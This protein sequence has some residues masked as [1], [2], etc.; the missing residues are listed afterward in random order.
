MKRPILI[1]VVG[2]IIGIIIG[3]YF[4]ISIA[5]FYVVLFLLYFTIKIIYKNIK[6][7]RF[8]FYSISR[9]LRY[10]KL[11]INKKI[12]ILLIVFSCISNLIINT[13]IN[14]YNQIY[15]T[16]KNVEIIAKIEDLQEEKQYQNKYRINTLKLNGEEININFFLITSSKKYYEYGD[17]VFIKGEYIA[18]SI[19]RNYGGFDYSKY[20]KT[21]NIYGTIKLTNI[22]LIEKQKGF[23][24]NKMIYNLRDF[25]KDN[26]QKY[27]PKDLYSIYLGLI[28][29]DTTYIEDETMDNF[30]DSNMAHIL[31]VSGM[32]ISYIVI[33]ISVFLNKIFGKRRTK[34]IS[35]FIIL[36]Y[37]FITGFS[38]SIIRASIM[39]IM[40]LLSGLFNRKDDIWNSIA[41]S[42]FIILIYNPFL[43]TSISLQY[44]YLGIIGIIVF[45]NSI[46]QF[47]KRKSEKH[48]RLKQIVAF[49]LSIQIFIFPLS[50]YYFNKFGIYFIFTNIVLSVII[51]PLIVYSF[52]FL[53]LL[54]IRFPLINIAAIPLKAGITIIL[55][56]SNISKLPFSK[57]NV[58]TPKIHEIIIF[59]IVMILINLIYKSQSKKKLTNS[60][61]RLKL[62]YQLFKY[63]LKSKFNNKR[64]RRKLLIICTIIVFTIYSI[65]TIRPRELQIHFVDVGQGDCC[66]IET[67][68]NKTI[69]I[70][71][72]GAEFGDFDVGKN[73]VLPYLLDI[74]YTKID[75]VIISHFDTDHI[76][77]VLTIIKELNVGQVVVSKQAEISSN[78]TKFKEIINEK[79]TKVLVV[80]DNKNINNIQEENNTF[81]SPQKL[82]IEEDL[83]FDFLWPYSDNL[84]TENPLNNNSIVCKLHYKDFSMLFTGD[85]EEIAEKQ[86]LQRYRNNYSRLDSK[87]LKIAHHGS[88]TSTS[89]E[90]LE[91][92]NP[93]I[94][95]IGVGQNNKF[96]HPNEEVIK[97][98]EN[99]G[100]KI[101][102]T[103]QMGEITIIVNNQGKVT[104][105][106]KNT[107]Q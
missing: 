54:L 80:G 45:Y 103:D 1:A 6:I 40:V 93:Q 2:Y 95:L 42:L 104:I 84:I 88:K 100:T 83:F 16:P 70:D 34:I 94:A 101:Y 55:G 90:F 31:A 102:R 60:G 107:F 21:I 57:I 74:G 43:I 32:H 82:K 48:S 47:L 77:G 11:F 26:A 68:C 30:R 85:I 8:S 72:G 35:I 20:L 41:I 23:D 5:L 24:F 81:V 96:G 99:I 18:P 3:L 52:L 37:C 92:V 76:G 25:I 50:I 13:K 91:A 79:K 12:I 78:Y 66:F 106:L 7:K 67:P 19:Q 56:L 33:G 105:L 86:I 51:G 36:I 61:L 4:K 44:S 29:G 14:C 46:L 73:T 64:K 98:L 89:K 97:R 53:I 22:K 75:Y 63:K 9:Y 62:T 69:L 10:I 71:G 17:I 65:I 28:L 87:A 15:N 39:A 59:Y 58:R 49:S 27:L 38:P